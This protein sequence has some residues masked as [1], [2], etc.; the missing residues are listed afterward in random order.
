MP[1]ASVLKATSVCVD[2]GAQH[3]LRKVSVFMAAAEDVAIVGASGSG[4]TTLLYALSGLEKIS[5][6]SVSLL[7]QSLAQ[8][9][10]DGLCELRLRRVGFVFQ[11][12]DLVPELTLAE[13]VALPLE[14]AG[15][16][17]R[18][19][20]ERVRELVAGLDLTECADRRPRQVSGGQAQRCAVARAVAARPAVVF[21]DEPTGALDTR[22]RERV[23]DL[24]H[25]QVAGVGALLVTVTH[26]PEVAARSRRVISLR[27][28]RIESDG[29]PVTDVPGA[30]PAAG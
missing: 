8:L 28:G 20:T 30:G 4:K 6:G 24:L 15:T 1:R 11:S 29:P 22:N 21:A 25:D 7:G 23:L 10:A 9:S 3:V 12:A 16:P 5:S 19:R 18:E 13:N 26:D 27:D 17:R 14:L 2:Y